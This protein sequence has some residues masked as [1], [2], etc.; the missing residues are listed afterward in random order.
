MNKNIWKDFAQLNG[1]SQEEF[2]NEIILAAMSVMSIKLDKEELSK[3]M[4][5]TKGQY[6][7]R[8]I[9]NDK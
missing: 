4:Q 6:T 2:S 3:T 9:D 7:L 1:M 5:I 8:L